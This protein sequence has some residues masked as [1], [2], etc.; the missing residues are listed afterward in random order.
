MSQLLILNSALSKRKLIFSP[1]FGKL[2]MNGITLGNSGKRSLSM[3][4]IS[5][6]V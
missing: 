2:K 4:L 5:K 1:K 3:G 6:K